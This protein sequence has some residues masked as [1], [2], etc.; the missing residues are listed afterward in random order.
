MGNVDYCRAH[1][2]LQSRL[3]L[4][5]CRA[6]S[7]FSV[8]LLSFRGRPTLPA[9]IKDLDRF[10]A[11][12]D[13]TVALTDDGRLKSINASTTGQGETVVKSAITAAATLASVPVAAVLP[14]GVVSLFNQNILQKQIAEAKP[15]VVCD[16]VR[17][18]SLTS[19]EQLPQISLVQ[20]TVIRGVPSDLAPAPSEDQKPLLE[21]LRS[22]GLDFSAAVSSGFL[23]EELQP[24]GNPREVVERAEVSLRVQRMVMFK[25]T[26]KDSQGD[27]GSKSI[28]VPT[29][30]T[31]L[32]PIPKAALFG[33]QSFSLV[34]AE[35]GRISSIGYGRTAGAPG[36]L[37]A[38]TALA[39]TEI[40][41]D[42]AQ[43]ATMK[44]ASDLIA[45]QQRY[46][47]CKLKPTDCK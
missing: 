10:Y 33:K 39:G 21:M 1:D 29:S 9:S 18:W 31:F 4:G 36:A 28:P 20:T 17:R 30:N 7:H 3:K 12:A 41:E 16:V 38:L 25:T 47:N 5:N 8:N 22:A 42:N 11:D 2:Y 44:A 15:P 32:L 26:V 34:L 13:I 46:S 37:G 14:T 19:P 6:R 45:Q 43:A 23:Q 35:S 40:T 27:I 24:V